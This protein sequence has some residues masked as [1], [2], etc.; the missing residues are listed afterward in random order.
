MSIAG[1]PA[2]Q[3]SV[4]L[5]EDNEEAMLLVAFALEEYGQGR[6]RLQWANRLSDGLDQ[7][8]K[9]GVDVVLLY[10]GLP[11]ASGSTSYGWVR[12]ASPKTP[13]LVWTGEAREYTM[14]AILAG[15]V[16]DYLIKAH[17]SGLQIVESLETALAG[18]KRSKYKKHGGHREQGEDSFDNYD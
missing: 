3:K 1:A 7:I 2:L 18:T 15:G 10:L 12:A 13:I 14:S 4:L 16:E 6:Y 11:E 5:I 9:G 8:R 17:V